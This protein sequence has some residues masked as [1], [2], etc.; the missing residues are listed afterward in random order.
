MELDGSACLT[1]N[2]WGSMASK[3]LFDLNIVC[4]KLSNR[5]EVIVEQ[6]KVLYPETKQ[7]EYKITHIYGVA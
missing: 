4:I 7:P 5:V 6:L 3:I 2:T 1:T